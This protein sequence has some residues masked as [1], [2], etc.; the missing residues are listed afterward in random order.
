[1]RLRV[2]LGVMG[3]QAAVHEIRLRLELAFCTVFGEVYLDLYRFIYFV[4]I[5]FSSD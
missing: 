1:M 4:L 5:P 3:F 2:N